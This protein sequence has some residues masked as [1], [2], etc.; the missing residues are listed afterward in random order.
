M[1]FLFLWIIFEFRICFIF[2]VAVIIFILWMKNSKKKNDCEIQKFASTPL[3]KNII[4]VWKNGQNINV[5]VLLIQYLSAVC[6]L[7][8]K[9]KM[10]KGSWAG[11]TYVV[12][13]HPEVAQEVLKSYSVINKDWVYNIFHSWLGTGL[14]TSS[15][16]KW[17]SRRKLLTP[18]FHFRILEDFQ[19][20]FYEQANILVQK[21]I[22]TKEGEVVEMSEL[23]TLCTLDI[24]ADS[25]MGIQLKAQV[26]SDNNYVKAVKGITSTFIEWFAKPWYWFPPILYFSP[27]GKKMRRDIELVHDFARKV[28]R[29]KKGKLL[30]QLEEDDVI[31]DF[32]KDKEVLGIKKRRAF[33][34]L[35]VY[36]HIVSGDLTEEDI[37]EEVDT[38]M[39]EGHDTTGM[40]ISWT[41]YL[42]GLH[43]E[44]Q[45][46]VYQEL[47]HIF[48]DDVNRTIK[49][50]DLKEMKYLERVIKE[51]LRLFPSVP[52]ILRRNSVEI[53]IGK[54]T[55][56][57]NSSLC[58]YIYGI[59]HNSEVYEN[60]EVFD[61]D[62]FLPENCENRHPFA[63]LPFS[64]G[65]RNCIGQRFA[66][67]VMKT[68]CAH[69]LRN[70]KVHSLEHRE[71]VL[72]SGD[73]ILRP[74]EEI[75]MTIEKR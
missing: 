70:F 13:F 54:C 4:S 1:I 16:E 55:I 73:V 31:D 66:M 59:H 56:P 72:V 33:L 11:H 50:D 5:G 39:F 52:Y 45:E 53:K 62:R 75:K 44:T 2:F 43:H 48:P 17:R 61:P 47:C 41:L 65:P 12:L 7:F 68:V 34:D 28:I 35:L 3:L 8:E 40:G 38:F 63:Y 71:K 27:L 57:R 49:M 14:L 64:A 24:V 18:A 26:K 36:H 10:F 69:V 67:M 42:L 37:R 22:E 25:A 6:H 9:K 20:I 21:L 51:A 74:K 46:R 30:K 32:E 60:P 58:V 29:K 19:D 15:D 23:V